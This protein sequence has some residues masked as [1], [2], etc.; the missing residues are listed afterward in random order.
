MTA[1]L[2]RRTLA[3]ISPDVIYR[4][5]FS[6]VD[7]LHHSYGFE[8]DAIAHSFQDIYCDMSVLSRSRYLYIQDIII[9]RQLIDTSLWENISAKD[10]K[11]YQSTQ[12]ERSTLL[13]VTDEAYE[14]A[15]FPRIQFPGIYAS[16]RLPLI[17]NLALYPLDD[18]RTINSAWHHKISYCLSRKV[19]GRSCLQINLWL[20]LA[21]TVLTAIKLGCLIYT[22]KETKDMPLVTTGDA[23]VSFLES[24]CIY[25]AGICLLSQEEL[26]REL[27]G[28][29]HAG[30]NDAMPRHKVFQAIRLR[31]YCSVN[32]NQ[33][34]VY[35]SLYGSHAL[36]HW[37]MISI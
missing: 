1:A 11:N 10:C 23:I 13:F 14:Q 20:C 31:Y 26:E 9:S 34:V 7:L 17:T 36:L 12:T 24:P 22:F 35:V 32:L 6:Y 8:R 33:W 2:N 4:K 27:R 3:F 30:Q 18:K 29:R 16:G 25:S 19:A 28:K 21:A 37:S 5:D 15:S